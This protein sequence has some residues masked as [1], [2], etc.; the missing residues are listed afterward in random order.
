MH[1]AIAMVAVGL[2]LACVVSIAYLYRHHNKLSKAAI[3][4]EGAPA[5][6]D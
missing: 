2:V 1:S 6:R 5:S 3:G 4:Q